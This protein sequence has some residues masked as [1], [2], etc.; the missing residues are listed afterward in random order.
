MHADATH[1]E[2][3]ALQPESRAEERAR[4][5]VTTEEQLAAELLRDAL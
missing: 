5:Q 1:L 3:V 4:E 2:C